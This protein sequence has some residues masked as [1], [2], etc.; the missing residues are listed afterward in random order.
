MLFEKTDDQIPRWF[1]VWITL[2]VLV[3]SPLRYM[4]LQ[5]IVA[6]AYMVQSVGAF[7]SI[8]PLAM[9]VPIVA[10]VLYFVGLGVP[11]LLT[12]YIPFGNLRTPRVTTGRLLLGALAAPINAIGGYLAF[13]WVLQFAAV[14][15][16]WLRAEDVIGAT[17]GPA[18]VT[19]DLALKHFMPLPMK[20]FYGDVTQ[21]DREMLR[22][23]VASYYLG[24]R[25]EARYVHLAYPDLFK[26]LTTGLERGR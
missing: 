2:C 20:E 19:Y 10:S 16:H 15:V 21:S 26:R 25:A 6:S 11:L 17:N 23:H 8:L 3:L 7:F 4:M 22:N 5:I 13:F 24:N 12:L 9:Y 14:S 1:V 18:F